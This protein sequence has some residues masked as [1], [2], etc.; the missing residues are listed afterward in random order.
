MEKKKKSLRERFFKT[1]PL[2][3]KALNREKLR[4]YDMFARRAV[5][6]ELE[7]ADETARKLI[8]RLIEDG[9]RKLANR[10]DK[11]MRREIHG[12]LQDIRNLPAAYMPSVAE[13]K[14]ID[15]DVIEEIIDI[16][17]GMYGAA[18]DIRE[19]LYEMEEDADILR[20]DFESASAYLQEKKRTIKEAIRERKAIIYAP[21]PRD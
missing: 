10:V 1:V 17:E 5:M 7:A 2:V 18:Y 9:D 11:R 12:L 20:E 3:G 14:K 8:T 15:A 19:S 4:D 13:T 21:H 16:D 6:S